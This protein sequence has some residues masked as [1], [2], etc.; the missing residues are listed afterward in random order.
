MCKAIFPLKKGYQRKAK[1]P[2]SI[3]EFQCEDFLNSGSLKS[4]IQSSLTDMQCLG[5]HCLKKEERYT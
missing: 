4:F 1:N 5:L 2:L 3:A